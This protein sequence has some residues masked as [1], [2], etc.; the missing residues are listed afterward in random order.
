MFFHDMRHLIFI[1]PVFILFLIPEAG[2]QGTDVSGMEK[3]ALAYFQQKEYAQSLPLY[4]KLLVAYPRD[5]R[6]NYYAGVSMTELGQEPEKAI[7]RLKIASLKEVPEDV[8]FYLG[9]ACYQA[10][11]YDEAI[12]WYERFRERVSGGV[13]KDYHLDKYITEAKMGRGQVAAGIRPEGQARKVS[14]R[15][16]AS[17]TALVWRHRAD[18]LEAVIAAERKKLA[19]AQ[20]RPEQ[21]QWQQQIRQHEQELAHCREQ[22]GIWAVRAGEGNG[23][24]ADDYTLFGPGE[25]HTRVLPNTSPVSEEEAAPFLE[26]AGKDF[27]K[28]PGMRK[29]MSS[30]DFVAMEGFREMSRQGNDLMKEAWENEQEAARQEMIV[31]TSASGWER[32]RAQNRM[33]SLSKEKISKRLQAVKYFQQAND[34][35]Y[36]L[37]KKYIEALLRKGSIPAV[38]K[39]QGTQFGKEAERSHGKALHLRTQAEGLPAERRYDKLMEANAYELMALDHQRK[40]VATLAGLMPASQKDMTHVAVAARQTDPRKNKNVTKK[41]KTTPATYVAREEKI[42]RKPEKKESPSLKKDLAKYPYGLT[43]KEKNMYEDAGQIPEGNDMPA[44]VNYRLQVGVFSTLPDM[45]YFQG[46][47]PLFKERIPGKTLTR[48]YAGQF[49][50]YGEAAHALLALREMGYKDA[51]VVGYY[52]GKRSPVSRIRPLEDEFPYE[53]IPSSGNFVLAGKNG[54]PAVT[55]WKKQEKKIEAQDQHLLYRVQVGV[56]RNPLNREK[57]SILGEMAGREHVVIRTK[58]NQGYYIY[59]IGNFAT[60]E[61]ANAFRNKLA[62]RGISGCFVTAYKN[63]ARILIGAGAGN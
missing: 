4:N 14:P 32:T 31:N 46:M 52:N 45:T 8:F 2:A 29:I 20:G 47:Y 25:K 15:E 10:G 58:N 13:R 6:Y 59:A 56:F 12:R 50:T 1:L 24:K 22:A 33:R 44:G 5:P 35:E 39:K 27:Y 23:D 3:E 42:Y 61:E 30:E 11:R 26:L 37:N 43:I 54:T 28:E 48:Y 53:N 60:F 41:K 57:V 9:R 34:G 63:G 49:R 21:E 62:E 40:A 38:Q 17:F 7:Y 16:E 55:T 36:A 51:I 18:S 19:A